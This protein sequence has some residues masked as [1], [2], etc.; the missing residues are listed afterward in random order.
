MHTVKA[1]N[2]RVMGECPIIWDPLPL[3]FGCQD[4]RRMRHVHVV[5]MDFVIVT[6]SSVPILMES[7]KQRINTGD[8]LVVGSNY[9]RAFWFQRDMYMCPFF[10]S[11]STLAGT[12]RLRTSHWMRYW[13]WEFMKHFLAA[14]HIVMR[15]SRKNPNGR[16]WSFKNVAVDS[17]SNPQFTLQ[18]LNVR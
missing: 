13:Y 10:F 14:L 5:V 3:Y 2:G 12:L 15:L 4:R 7:S 8:P 16:R 11:E 6:W 9:R 18:A 1:S 17:S